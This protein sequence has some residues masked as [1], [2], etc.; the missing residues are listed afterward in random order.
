MSLTRV[1][2]ASLTGLAL[3][4]GVVFADWNGFCGN[5]Q[6]IS[7]NAGACPTCTLMIADNPELQFYGVVA[8]NGWEAELYWV[9]RNEGVAAGGGE[10]NDRAG[11]YAEQRFAIDMNRE[12]DRL[13]MRMSHYNPALGGAITAEY[14]CLD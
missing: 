9:N 10:W 12:G 14:I 4:S 5:Y 6:Q 1:C 8:N 2:F 7:S 11:S 13:F 3:S